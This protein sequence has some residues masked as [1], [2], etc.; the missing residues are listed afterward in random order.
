M[1]DYK[2]IKTKTDEPHWL[3][4]IGCV[5]L[6]CVFIAS[7]ILLAAYCAPEANRNIW[8]SYAK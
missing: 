6:M 2:N 7:V 1:I 3:T 8:V 4:Q 5:I